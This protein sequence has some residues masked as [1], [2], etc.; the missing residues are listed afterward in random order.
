M[1]MM[2]RMISA[3]LA[4]AMLLGAEQAAA[5]Q[6]GEG[7]AQGFRAAAPPAWQAQDPA[8]A[9]YR[10]AREHLNRNDYARAAT[11][12]AAIV[13][14][15]P[16]SAYAG[17]ALYFQAF[18]LYRQGGSARLREALGALERQRA[19]Y[20]EAATRSDAEALAVRI[21]GELARQGDSREAERLVNT[22]GG[23]VEGCPE[24]DEIRVAA[25]NA[26]L[27]MNA[28][29]AQPILMQVLGR[30]DAC[31]APLRRKA[32]FMLS[33]QR[34]A[35]TENVLLDLVRNDPDGE[36]R[37]QAVFW[38]SQVPTQR[39]VEAL[40]EV[41][42]GDG[43]PKLQERALFAL[44]QHKSPQAGQALRR[45]AEQP[46]APGRLR[47][48]A[49]FWLGQQPAA[50]NAA[51]LRQLYGRLSDE[52]LK[53]KVIFS[54][55]QQGAGRH[56]DWLMEI[57]LDRNESVRLRKQ[58]LFWAGQGGAR[59]EDLV[60][61]Y[62]RVTDREIKDQLIF[63]YSQRRDPAALDQL[64]EI[65]RRE[66]DQELRKKAIFWLSQSKD[67]RVAQVLLE[68]IGN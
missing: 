22:A 45:Y 68:L 51:F 18:A 43:D 50:E 60:R 57:A 58:A 30:R 20:A 64:I 10:Q 32:V 3:G 41:L 67:P 8:D 29:Q 62:G 35:E 38:L 4:I 19:T 7:L 6:R 31:S 1:D 66:P 40:Q 13:S 42:L 27:H 9:L 36:V 21:Q 59:I 61:L 55:A 65:A 11:Q 56:G 39:A 33:Q 37:E 34:T 23:V 16:R 48:N 26:L 49:I 44:S 15:Y 17:D 52:S 28:E 12:F 54:L 25:L 63:V 47:E 53:E 5:Q 24:A 14:R 2:G 46:D